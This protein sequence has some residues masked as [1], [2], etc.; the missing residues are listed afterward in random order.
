MTVLTRGSNAP[1][2]AAAF[3]VEVSA[4]AALDVSALL[5]TESGKV[6]SDDDFIFYNAPTGPGVRHVPADA[7]R[8]DA[9]TIDTNAIPS[10]IDKIVVTAS[11]D[12]AG[13]TFAG[14][15]PVATLRDIPSG[16]VL[17]TFAPDRLGPETALILVEIYRRGPQWKIRGVGQGYSNGLAGI[18]TDFGIAVDEEE[19]TP[20][21]VV[22]V[23]AAAPVRL[24][25]DKGR[26]SLQKRQSVSLTKAGQP[27]L[28]MVQMALGWD[29]ANGRRV[30]LDASCIAFD[31]NRKKLA[32]CWFMKLAILDGA[33][34]H[35]GDNLTGRGEGDDEIISV[36]LGRLPAEVMGLVFTVNSFSGHK[37]SDV[38]NA[39][40]RL[41]DAGSGAELVRFDLSE[42]KP[43]TGVA[44]CKLIREPSGWVMTALGEF[45]DAKTVRGMVKPAG[46]ML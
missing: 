8:P 28:S 23:P 14:A 12:A 41:I 36:D 5:V 2:G 33:I 6:R 29:P 34:Q 35:S 21:P 39:F 7:Q 46:Q 40:C 43:H 18:A 22:E 16:A 20:Q 30:D 13:A 19:A 37:F 45:V 38:A 17:A 32:S 4:A 24:N 9:I 11:L 3:A 44:M 42:A 25:L 27:L 26:V 1:L 31:G 10:Q 15:A